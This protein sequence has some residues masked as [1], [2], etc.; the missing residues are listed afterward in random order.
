MIRLLIVF[1]SLSELKLALAAVASS[2]PQL[3]EAEEVTKFVRE[4]ETNSGI[5]QLA[6]D[7]I[8]FLSLRYDHKWWVDPPLTAMPPPLL[9]YVVG[10][11]S[12]LHWHD[13]L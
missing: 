11:V 4:A 7:F 1:R 10:V 6:F 12:R 9:L 2:T 3:A 13:P 8:R 5:V